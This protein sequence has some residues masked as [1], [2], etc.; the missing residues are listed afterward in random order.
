MESTYKPTKNEILH[1]WSQIVTQTGIEKYTSEEW[2]E[3]YENFWRCMLSPNEPYIQIQNF[4]KYLGGGARQQ[5]QQEQ[6]QEEQEQQEGQDDQEQ[7]EEQDD[8]DEQDEQP[9]PL[10]LPHVEFNSSAEETEKA[11]CS[12]SCP[13]EVHGKKGKHKKNRKNKNKNKNKDKK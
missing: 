7:Q 11:C 8:Q 12:Y 1:M 5:P 13:P 3:N 6:E 9:L 10:L 2:Q 4:D